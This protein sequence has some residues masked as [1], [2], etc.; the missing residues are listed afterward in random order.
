MTMS[1]VHRPSALKQQNKKHN[2][3]GHRSKGQLT[4]AFK[5]RVSA[6]SISK[7]CKNELSRE[8]RRNQ[9]KQLRSQKREC[10]AAKKRG[11][12]T[13]RSPPFLVTITTLCPDI[14]PRA[15]IKQLTSCDCNAVVNTSP[16]G[17]THIASPRF[18]Q[19]FAF[20]IPPVNDLFAIL[21]SAKVSNTVLLVWPNDGEVGDAGELLLS[22][23]L[24][25]GLPT[26]VH[27]TLDPG[28]I[29]KKRKI[30]MKQNLVLEISS[31]F[32]GEAKF[33]I[34]ER[35][36]DA[37]LLLR[38][39]GSQKQRPVFFRDHRPHLMAEK[40]LFDGE[41]SSGTL[42]VHG[43]V[44][45]QQLSVNGL[46]H[47]PGWGE[48]QMSHIEMVDDPYSAEFHKSKNDMAQD[49]SEPQLLERADPEKQVSLISVNEVDPMEGEQ[50]WPTAEELAEAEAEQKAQKKTKR[51]PKGTSEYQ[52]AWILDEDEDDADDESQGDFE[53]DMD[54]DDDP[55][56][57]PQ[58]AFSQSGKDSSEEDEDDDEYETM[59]V[60]EADDNY[61]EKIDYG[62]ELDAFEKLKAER[63]DQLFPDEVDTPQDMPARLRFSKY[64]GLQ[65]FRTTVWDTKENL[66]VD[67][68]RIFQFN[69]FR[70]TRKRVFKE[71]MEGA[72]LGWYVIVHIK[73]VPRHL[74]ES[75]RMSQSPLVVFGLLNHEQKMSVM[76]VVMK[77]H[78]S[79]HFRAIKS[80]ERLIF[81]V[82]FRRF[83]NCPIFSEHS[84]GNKFKF[85]R[86]FRPGCTVVASMFAP[87]TFPP[88]SVMVF[89]ERPDGAQDL[90][91]TGSLYTMDPDRVVCK[92]AVL[93][94]HPFK[95]NRKTAVVRYLFFNR[96]DVAWFKPV[97]LRTKY[98]RRGHIKEPLGTHG[99]MKCFFDG[100]L[101]SQDTV[102][103]NLY[104]RMFPKW[105]FDPHVSRPPPLFT[106]KTRED[107][108]GDIFEEDPSAK[109]AK[110]VHFHHPI[111]LKS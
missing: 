54:D 110:K 53:S 17:V 43:C 94:G 20:V 6:K 111:K 35:S 9:A 87:I 92:R 12:G 79:G 49:N 109:R 73:D 27:V 10:T 82:G 97:E 36:E 77:S 83:A 62:E 89:R 75:H 66:P 80:K 81:H 61:D 56:I 93:S 64:R 96:D 30:R 63:Q 108:T 104:K 99:H 103:M 24:A 107:I 8:Q 15:V 14:N 69:N 1:N 16:Q 31:R 86:Y 47:I 102:M 46:V 44:R 106:F 4:K 21:D 11:L 26:P 33:H 37:L 78:P 28:E 85:E 60:T 105:N 18:K 19:R 7:K 32:P 88:A 38:Q 65:S 57:K 2:T 67:Y 34:L 72:M 59:T 40:V 51:V 74:Y 23:I 95:I 55:M 13:A 25:Q 48:F 45:G 91:A 41:G 68:A 39:I 5:G 71:E 42:Q 84:T 50:T 70:N 90:V 3:L 100:Q 29:S 52:A 22:C 98:G 58:D 76:N 101:K